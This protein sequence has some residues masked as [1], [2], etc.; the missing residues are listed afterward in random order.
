MY[1]TL[2]LGGWTLVTPVEKALW[3][4]ESR[5]DSETSLAEIAEA[6]G[7]SRF[8][9]SR[10]FGV[11]TGHSVMSYLR[12]RRLSRAA[13]R[14]TE[15]ASIILNV[16]L[17]AGYGSHEAFTRAFR[18]QFGITPEAVRAQGHTGNIELVAAI[19]VDSGAFAELEA[20]RREIGEALL[21]A[22]L[23][24]R[25]SFETNQGIPFQ[26]QRFR[27]YIGN[28]PGQIGGTTYGVCCNADAAGSF[29]YLAGV[30]VANF[31]DVPAELR[32]IRI[33]GQE[34]VV[35]RHRGHVSGLR[36]C[37]YTIWNRWLPASGHEIADSPDFELY[38][39]DF[40]STVG[41]G[42][43]EIWLPIRT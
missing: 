1:D 20:P 5:L 23:G 2:V 30:A 15:P 32:R 38:G 25:Y 14:L 10:A 3:L 4:I 18:D 12:R 11:A 37:V 31:A 33:P 24:E 28:V 17:D 22:G 26:W 7:V 40:D 21:I 35:F 19:G 42:T 9:L 16:A 34:Y 41:T 13:Q 27:P 6:A 36:R 39:E 29:E 43:I 8:H